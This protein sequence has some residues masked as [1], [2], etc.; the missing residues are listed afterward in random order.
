M[1]NYFNSD[2]AELEGHILDK[3][4]VAALS[5]AGLEDM[6]GNVLPRCKP[7]LREVR[8]RSMLS[9]VREMLSQTK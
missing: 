9:G 5:T 7:W 3:A 2:L 4:I 6:I 1:T 8:K